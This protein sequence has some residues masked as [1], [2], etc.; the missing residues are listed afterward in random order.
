MKKS[1]DGRHEVIL[2]KTN[3][4]LV[5]ID[6]E[7]LAEIVEAQPVAPLPFV[8][9]YVEGLVNIN[10]EIMP[11]V[12][13]GSLLFEPG[14]LAG[15]EPANGNSG[16]TLL[17]V[18]IDEIP[19][20]LRIDQV[21]EAFSLEASALQAN[22]PAVAAAGPQLAGETVA[23][24]GKGRGRGKNRE[25]QQEAAVSTPV[26]DAP[27][28]IH[29]TFDF[30]GESVLL[31]D[32]LSLK[33]IVRSSPRPTGRQGFLGKV[34]ETVTKTE[35]FNEYLICEVAGKEFAVD[36]EEVT[37]IVIMEG[38]RH[39]P[40]APRLIVGMGLV[41][42][43]PRLVLDMAALLGQEQQGGVTAGAVIMVRFNDVLCGILADR[44]VGL[45]TI[46]HTS[47]RHNKEKNNLT[48][49]R[50]DGHTLTRVISFASLLDN[51]LMEKIR[52]Y[53]PLMKKEAE[54]AAV[55]QVELLR[56][57]LDGD[58]YALRLAD[59]HRIVSGKHIEPLLS[60]KAYIMGTMELEGKVVPVINL[61]SQLGYA[62]SGISVFEC[63]V[64]NDG[65][66]EWG[67]GIGETEQ[68]IKVD[69]PMIDDINSADIRYV[70][71]YSNYEDTL[72]TILNVPAICHENNQTGQ[73]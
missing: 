29:G 53:L 65:G 60:E 4:R 50:E 10:G 36:L 38:I 54:Q 2:F 39:L 35:Q 57:S 33:D 9:A 58:C 62:E 56:F 14:A 73:A 6:I 40:C 45:E 8:P 25:L 3:D 63:I 49:V 19:I 28:Y 22:Q 46:P 55:K 51:S 15:N 20:A 66:R 47:Q 16:K 13:L 72:L 27:A 34:T 37:E 68:I 11:Q 41:R 7:Y 24:K 42:G 52:P 18:T 69:E 71:A 48:V 43:K 31:F 17:I 30:A 59:V 61:V 32:A 5:A 64:V 12:N 21:R 23:G 1:V 70:S 26:S 67:L 44:M